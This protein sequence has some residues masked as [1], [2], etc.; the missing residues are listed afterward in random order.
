MTYDL[1]WRTNG[2]LY[3]VRMANGYGVR[4]TYYTRRMRE[5]EIGSAE[6]RVRG[7]FSR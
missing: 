2:I 3:D 6:M 4:M 7:I 1:V 5:I